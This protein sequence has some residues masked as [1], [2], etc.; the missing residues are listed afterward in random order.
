M[1]VKLIE[2]SNKI[3]LASTIADHVY[4]IINNAIAEKGHASIVLPG[5]ST[6]I[7]FLKCLNSKN[8]CWEKL[9]V[10]LTDERCVDINSPDSNEAM[11]IKYFPNCLKGQFRGLTI[12][13]LA[14]HE[15]VQTATN[16]VISI[17]R[18]FDVTVVGMGSDGHFASLFPHNP[19]SALGLDP[20]NDDLC[21][22]VYPENVSPDVPRISQTLSSI[23]NSKNLILH[24]IGDEKK[25][26]YEKASES[27]NPS[28]YPVSALLHQDFAP[29]TVYWSR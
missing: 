27:L 12:N 23:I 7:A 14:N 2:K 24:I 28:T 16:T 3:I 6:P 1:T 13:G 18:P 11:I 17:P 20:D 9:Y 4:D 15:A 26:I 25:A 29:I 22:M 5:G 8:L 10:T 21:T 19:D